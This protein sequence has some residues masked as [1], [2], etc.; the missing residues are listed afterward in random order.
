MR[1][2][3][4]GEKLM[5]ENRY[6]EISEYLYRSITFTF[7]SFKEMGVFIDRTPLS[8]LAKIRKVAFIAHILPRDTQAC[9]RFIEGKFFQTE[10][11]DGIALLKQF[12]SLE[13]LE[14]NFFPSIILSLTDSRTL[15]DVVKPLD[16]L[17][18]VNDIVLRIPNTAYE[19]TSNNRFPVSPRLEN[20]GRFMLMRPE[21][22]ASQVAEHGCKAYS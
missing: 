12:K 2:G 6:L 4:G 17:S 10:D 11:E 3:S 8:L 15:H 16:Q 13:R 7:S 20:A 21:V 18:D 9:I 5:R 14:I 19:K 22:V 1:S